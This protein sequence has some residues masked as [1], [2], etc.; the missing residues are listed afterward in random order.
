M[1]LEQRVQAWILIVAGVALAGCQ[2]GAKDDIDA[3]R[4]GF[5]LAYWQADKLKNI[6][7]LLIVKGE[8]DA[9]GAVTDEV[10]A[11]AADIAGRLEDYAATD[12][13]I[14]LEREYLPPIE[15]GARKR[16]GLGI[17]GQLLLSFG[18][19]FE[20]N[21]LFTEAVAVLRLLKLS[22]E[23]QARA[24]DDAQLE[25]WSGFVEDIEPVFNRVRGMLGDCRPAA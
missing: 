3:Y 24:P 8:R 7:K 21:L 4:Q 12:Q 25:L 17:A 19:D 2:A 6:D 23:M 14:D 16:M 9:V 15:V 13:S 10:A 18:C 5:S 22:E 20:Q 1:C 11:I